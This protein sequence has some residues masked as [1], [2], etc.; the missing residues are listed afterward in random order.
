[1]VCVTVGAIHGGVWTFSNIFIWFYLHEFCPQQETSSSAAARDHECQSCGKW[2]GVE[3]DFS[4]LGG[5]QLKRLQMEANVTVDWP[6]RLINTLYGQKQ[7]VT[8]RSCLPIETCREAPGAQF[9]ADV[10]AVTQLITDFIKKLTKAKWL[11][12]KLSRGQNQPQTSSL[13]LSKGSN[14]LLTK[15]WRPAKWGNGLICCYL[16]NL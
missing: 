6:L 10:S 13:S 12:L 5:E 15:L 4:Q 7:W 8:Y 1:M 16:V 14:Y 2:A 9:Y 3:L 11:K